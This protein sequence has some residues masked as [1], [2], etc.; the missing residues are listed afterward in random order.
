MTDRPVPSRSRLWLAWLLGLALAIPA[1]WVMVPIAVLP[2]FLGLYFFLPF[3]LLIGAMMYRLALP[4]APAPRRLLILIGVVTGGALWSASLVGEYRYLPVGAFKVV[5]ASIPI[6]LDERR[7]QELRDT[8]AERIALQLQERYPPGGMIGYVRWIVGR[9][10]LQ[11]PRVIDSTTLG[12]RTA[13]GGWRWPVRIVLS[14]LLTV[15]AIISQLLGLAPV[16]AD[17]PEPV[18]AQPGAG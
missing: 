6:V 4:A 12:Y 17:K 8:I 16:K 15:G 13:G 2:W 14:L 1:G 9:Q 10:R 3:G 7:E 18:E 11:V 5:R